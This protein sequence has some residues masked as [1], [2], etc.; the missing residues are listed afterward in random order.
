MTQQNLDELRNRANEQ[1]RKTVEDRR[2]SI[3]E[4]ARMQP[5]KNSDI[6]KYF[7]VSRQTASG[8]LSALAKEGVLTKTGKRKST[9]YIAA[10]R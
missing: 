3:V 8:D 7:S 9:I 5:V 6:Q 4:L 1:R 2:A 10:S